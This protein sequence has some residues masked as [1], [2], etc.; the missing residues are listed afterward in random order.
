[1]KPLSITIPTILTLFRLIISPILIPW[2]VVNYSFHSYWIDMSIAAL[3]AVVG[4]TD[5]LD[6]YIA[7][8]YG[9]MSRLGALLDPLA[10]KF[11]VSSTLIALLV[12]GRIWYGWVLIFISRE[13]FVMGLRELALS[14][15]LVIP[16]QIGGKFKTAAQLLYLMGALANIRCVYIYGYMIE[17]MLL[18][19]ALILTILSGVH[20][21]RDCMTKLYALQER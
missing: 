17:M 7:R 12:V 3:F 4:V 9:Q 21:Y 15:A 2:L 8:K 10:D 19:A 14:Y 11:L 5:F 6:G 1:M 18:E 13:F 16:V 20:Y